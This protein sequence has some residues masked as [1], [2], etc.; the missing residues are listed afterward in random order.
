MKKITISNI[1]KFRN[2]LK[3]G[4]PTIGGWMQI[5]NSNIAEIMSNSDYDW[6]TLDMEHGIFSTKCLPDIFRSI[7]LNNKLPLV[8]LPNKKIEVLAQALDAGTGGIII[9]NLNSVAEIKK[10]IDFCYYPP[11]GKRGVGFSRSN[12]FGKH[13]K[14]EKTKPIIIG[15]IENIK[16]VEDLDKIILIKGLDAVLIGP[17]DLSSSMNMPGK[18]KNREFKKIIKKIVRICKKNNMPCGIHVMTPE[19]KI[20][21]K[22]IR[23][24]Y[25]F[26]PYATDTVLLN[27]S[28]NKSFKK[29]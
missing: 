5:S 22:Y 7:E 26:L 14:L 1:K 3:K 21:K 24:G 15:M 4:K 23:E 20:L 19:N 9:P 25:Q 13:F 8:R 16:A 18:F 2:T 10:I 27:N 6:I 12:L 17:Y 11:K 28:L 29:K